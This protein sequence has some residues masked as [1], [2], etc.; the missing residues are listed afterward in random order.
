MTL[1]IADQNRVRTLTLNQPEALNAFN[2]ALYDA[3]AQ[4]LLSPVYLLG[5]VN[6]RGAGAPAGAN[7]NG[8]DLFET[9]VCDHADLG[10]IYQSWQMF[11][12]NRASRRICDQLGERAIQIKPGVFL[13]GRPAETA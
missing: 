6:L 5:S 2:E 1:L 8:G 3:T 9:P 10:S 4:A 11:L 7:Y 12:Q 13:P